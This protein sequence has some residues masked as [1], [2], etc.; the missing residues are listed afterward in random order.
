MI[1]IEFELRREENHS[2]FGQEISCL[3]SRR[4]TVLV[5]ADAHVSLINI[6]TARN[7]LSED[8]RMD[9]V[10]QTNRSRRQHQRQ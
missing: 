3:R 9:S 8:E 10:Q 7:V 4:S 1:L 6:I 5:G 2:I